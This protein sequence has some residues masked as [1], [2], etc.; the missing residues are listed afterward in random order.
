MEGLPMSVLAMILLPAMLTLC[1]L[2]AEPPR[3]PLVDEP[4]SRELPPKYHFGAAR[5][6]LFTPDGKALLFTDDDGGLIVW[7]L[8]AW[9]EAKRLPAKTSMYRWYS[10]SGDGKTLAVA[11]VEDNVRLLD[12]STWRQIKEIDAHKE[13]GPVQGTIRLSHDGKVF[14]AKLNEDKIWLYDVEKGKTRAVLKGH[15]TTLRDYKFSPDA[16]LLV[17]A[18]GDEG[19]RERPDNWPAELKFWDADT[20]KLLFTGSGTQGMIFDVAFS[21]DGK[22]LAVL[23]VDGTVR[24][25]DVAKRKEL[26]TLKDKNG[27]IESVAFSADS[28]WVLTVGFLRGDV[29]AWHAADGSLVKTVPSGMNTVRVGFSPDATKVLLQSGDKMKLMML[30][31][32]EK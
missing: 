11:T 20:G 13:A 29:R 27:S 7:D 25:W 3:P 14:A 21:P 28:Q 4:R 16:R 6:Y 31:A 1:M 32:P 23:A 2:R 12:T 15:A 8:E 22:L 18:S 24:V 5:D 30:T 17:T 26:Y 9:K 19:S 10:L